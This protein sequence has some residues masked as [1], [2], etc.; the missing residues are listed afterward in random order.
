MANANNPY[1]NF[2]FP[3]NG[4][5]SGSLREPARLHPMTIHYSAAATIILPQYRG[6]FQR[7]GETHDFRPPAT[8]EAAT[9]RFPPDSSRHGH[10]FLTF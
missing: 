5:T 2:A 4:T 1:I 7:I 6:F 3:R 8:R 9:C 10:G